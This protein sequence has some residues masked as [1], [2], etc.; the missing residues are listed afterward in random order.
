[1]TGIRGTID[2]LPGKQLALAVE[3]IPGATWVG[4]LV[5]PGNPGH[6][7]QRQD[8][9]IAAATLSLIWCPSRPSHL[10]ISTVHSRH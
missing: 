1:M 4:L 3:L 9:E 5:N 8:A 6:A 2:G 10:M 7:A